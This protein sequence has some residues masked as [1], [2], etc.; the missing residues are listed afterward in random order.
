MKW[1]THRIYQILT[2]TA[3]K[4]KQVASSPIFRAMIKLAQN[5]GETQQKLL[6]LKPHEHIPGRTSDVA[7]PQ[8]IIEPLN[9]VARKSHILFGL[10]IYL[11]PPCNL[12]MLHQGEATA[13]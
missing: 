9:K 12:G 8:S 1:H 3:D 7:F 4:A 2:Q 11:E 6:D 10:G 5:L 13:S